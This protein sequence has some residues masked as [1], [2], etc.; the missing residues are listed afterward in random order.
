MDI[1]DLQHGN[2]VR[3]RHVDASAH[4][5]RLRQKRLR[6]IVVILGIPLAWFWYREFTGNPVSPGLPSI[7]R[8]SPEM[9]LLVIL[10]VLMGAMTLIPYLGAGKSPHTML[11]PS[12]SK[13]RLADVVGAEATRR[14]AIDTLNLFLNHQTFADELGG[15]PRRGVLFEGAP[16]TGKT[17]LAKAL[18]AEAGVPFLFVSA[19]EDRKS[20]V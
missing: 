1:T 2:V 9:S 5:E 13:I 12:D 8:S 14:E 16:G 10:L 6:R 17:Y 18:A 4:R 3:G 7:I 15:S 19:S 11:R 20:V